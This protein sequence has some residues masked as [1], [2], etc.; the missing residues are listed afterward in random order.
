[1]V[2]PFG[3]G[4]WVLR[5]VSALPQ[6]LLAEAREVAGET[7]DG[8]WLELLDAL[9]QTLAGGATKEALQ[10]CAA[11]LAERLAPPARM[12]LILDHW[13]SLAARAQ[14]LHA[15]GPLTLAGG[16]PLLCLSAQA[17]RSWRGNPR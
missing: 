16:A 17:V 7:V 8:S 3:A 15:A 10:S 5:A 13:E 12:A 9:A 2:E 6:D 11:L 4:A 14:A 1:M